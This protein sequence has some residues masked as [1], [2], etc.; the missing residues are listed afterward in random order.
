MAAFFPEVLDEFLSPAFLERVRKK[1]HYSETQADE[2]QT[3]AGEMLP[4]IR[5]EAI[6]ESKAASVKHQ[7][8]RGKC[9][10]IYESVVMSLGNGIDCLQ[11]RYSEREQLSQSYMIDVLASEILM[12]GYDAYKR[13]IRANTDWHVVRYHFLGSEEEFP[14]EML[15]QLLKDLT[16]QITC[17]SAFCMCPQ[18]SVAFIAEL[19]QDESVQC[20]GVCAGCNNTYCFNTFIDIG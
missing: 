5:E 13:Y 11:E 7:N 20:K 17:N 2:F 6:W 1:F 10:V 18:K 15:P 9:N 3:V 19:T 14:F 8:Q 12:Q 4:L 16:Q